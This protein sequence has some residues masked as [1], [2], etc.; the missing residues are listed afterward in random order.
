MDTDTRIGKDEEKDK[1]VT[2]A[3]LFVCNHPSSRL[4]LMRDEPDQQTRNQ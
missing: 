2:N 4:S 1:L 3:W